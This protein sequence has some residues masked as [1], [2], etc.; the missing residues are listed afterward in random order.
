MVLFTDMKS[1]NGVWRVVLALGSVLILI[2]G[3]YMYNGGVFPAFIQRENPSFFQYKNVKPS[4][5]FNYPSLGK[6]KEIRVSSSSISYREPRSYFDGPLSAYVDWKE[7]SI[8]VPAD[9]WEKQKSNTNGIR[10]YLSEDEDTLTFR[11]PKQGT[12]IEFNV[13]LPGSY[14][15]KQEITTSI[16]D[17]FKEEV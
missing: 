16:I 13:S 4:F 15:R 9:Y 12:S 14:L 17:S 5:S 8:K 11:L 1:S 2:V 10:Y 6:R 3:V 7:I